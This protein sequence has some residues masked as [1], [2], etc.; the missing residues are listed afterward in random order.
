MYRSEPSVAS[1]SCYQTMWFLHGVYACSINMYSSTFLCL[2]ACLVF[3]PSLAI[4]YV[5]VNLVFEQ[6]NVCARG[7][8][9]CCVS[10]LLLFL[11][12]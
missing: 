10:L 8:L 11:S 2:C 12:T 3:G 1:C 6:I 4:F 9:L 5:T 7:I